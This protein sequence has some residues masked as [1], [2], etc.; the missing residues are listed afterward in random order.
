MC[1]GGGDSAAL[2]LIDRLGG[3]LKGR[4]RFYFHK[5]QKM[6]PARDD[7]DFANRAA[8]ATRQDAESFGNQKGGSAALRRNPEV[9]CGL[10]FRPRSERR[11]RIG[12]VT[13]RHSPCSLVRINA[14]W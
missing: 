4:A 8:P 14:R 13:Y 7:V 6:A 3:I 2:P 10:T 5:D 1:S 11:R 12:A 9:E